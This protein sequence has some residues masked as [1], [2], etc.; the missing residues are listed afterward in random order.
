M[1]EASVALPESVPGPALTHRVRFDLM[2]V[3]A[4]TLGT[5]AVSAALE[6]REWLTE[7]TRPLEHYQ[8][9]ELPLTF[10][11]LALAL[12]WFSWRRWR[13]AEE[14]LRL[15]VAAQEALVE[16]EA[17]YRLLSQ[18]YV[19]VQEEERRSLA[20]ELHDELGQCLNA[21]KVDAVS[22]RDAS[23][24]QQP[25]IEASATAIVDL[26]GHVYDMVRG[27]MQRLRPAALDALGLHDA[28][29]HL[30]GQWQRRNPAVDCRFQ[31]KGDLSGLGEVVNITVYRLVQECLTN[32]ARHAAATKVRV[33][34]E[35]TDAEVVV[36]VGDDG[37]GMD[38]Q[39]KRIGLGLVGL[40]E[41]VE[42]LQGRLDLTSGPGEGLQMRAS[43]PVQAAG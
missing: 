24:G 42:A 29:V 22:I 21:I 16:R 40:R 36:S 19:S 1:L 15:R 32:V 30:V 38:L 37:R 2:V 35:R 9:D 12:A 25:E 13:H 28:V 43:L 23:R 17:Q 8:I 14:E 7:A 33:A 34:L 41:R 6:L 4:V 18:K 11:A 26:S 10:G 3:A 39:A 31:A 20:R 27:I 5:F